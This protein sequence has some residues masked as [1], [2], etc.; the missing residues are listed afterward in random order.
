MRQTSCG[1]IVLCLLLLPCFANPQKKK[2][3]T[4]EPA[5]KRLKRPT[6]RRSQPKP[7]PERLSQLPQHSVLPLAS[8]PL[9]MLSVP[10]NTHT[11]V[12]EPPPT[13]PSAL[14]TCPHTYSFPSSQLKGPFLQEPLLTLDE[15]RCSVLCPQSVSPFP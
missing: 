13:L 9:P 3:K 15:D 12:N 8:G 4:T 10:C 7:L 14:D 5:F 11:T 6:P 2:P 1:G